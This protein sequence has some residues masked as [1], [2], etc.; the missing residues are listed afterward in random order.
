MFPFFAVLGILSCSSSDK[1]IMVVNTAPEASI[2]S[3]VDD[4]EF[5]QYT[6]ITFM[7]YIDD[8]QES[9]PDLQITWSSDIDETLNSDPATED[10]TVY[11]T[12]TELTPGEH[13]ITLNVVDERAS[14]G[15][16]SI[17]IYI[18]AAINEP[19]ISIRYPLPDELGT[20]NEETHFEAL[21]EDEQDEYSDLYV[22]IVSDLHGE[23][24]TGNADE[25]GIFVCDELLD[26]GTHLLTYT[27]I[28]LAENIITADQEYTVLALTEIDNDEDGF[29]EQ[30][31]DCDDSNSSVFPDAEEFPNGMDDDC[32]GIIDDGTTSYDDDGD[33]ICENEPCVGSIEPMCTELLSGD[34]NDADP[35][36]SPAATEV[37]DGVDNNCNMIVDDQTECFDDDG[38]GIN[39]QEGDCDDNDQYTYPFAP[40]ILN[41]IDNDCDGIIDEETTAFDDD[42]DCVCE[43]FLNGACTGT[44]NSACTTLTENDCDDGNDQVFP[45]AIEI[46]DGIDNNCDTLTDDPS[47]SDAQNWYQD[48]DTDTYGN[49]SSSTIACVAPSGYVSN[50]DDCNDGDAGLNPTTIWYLDNDSDGYGGSVSQQQCA[51]PGSTYILQ[52]GDCNDSFDTAYPGANE[53]CDGIDNNCDGTADESTALDASL[54]YHDADGDG[55]AGITSNMMSCTQPSGYFGSVT[56]CNDNNSAIHPGVSEICDGIDNNCNSN[57]DENVTTTYYLDFDNDGYGYAQSTT[58]A[59]S[60]PGGYVTNASDC[61]DSNIS[62]H[63]GATEVCDSGIDNN[64]NGSSDDNDSSLDTYTATM[65]YADS[66][67][68]GYGNG[69]QSLLRCDQP[70][71]YVTNNTD[72]NDNSNQANPSKTEVCDGIDND[73]D[74]S[75]DEP[76]AGGCTTYYRDYDGDGFG[77]GSMSQCTCS[78]SGYFDTTNNTD[79]YDSNSNVYPGQTSYFTSSRGDGS[80]DYDCNGVQDKYYTQNN[81]SCRGINLSFSDACR[82]KR[83]GWANGSTA[84]G[85]SGPYIVDDDSCVRDWFSCEEEPDTR[86]QRCR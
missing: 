46:C 66:D 20:E 73:C 52:S 59:C 31:G 71:N 81:G 30:E 27:V 1:S 83:E 19:S 44:S 62:I 84:C 15:E 4:T 57:I 55:H 82:M 24:C 45:S 49:P 78:T 69:S 70:S 53:Y 75:N 35:A 40:E 51:Q 39:E 17:S 74:G 5:I 72:C 54:W 22:S 18:E 13:T 11:F 34:C 28:D 86:T 36:L 43:T 38:D 14:Q 48:S 41:G 32:D 3:P 61:N 47:A 60:V 21:V 10:G 64:C 6:P 33:C 16:D 67:G 79:C 9:P 25:S 85:A 58:Q 50:S 68:D 7:G 37:C 42:G 2:Q 80:Y 76:N 63:P 26:V 8:A 77:D 29:N 56:D 12:T 65:W 23:I